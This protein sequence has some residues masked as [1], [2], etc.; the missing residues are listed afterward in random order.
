MQNT[1]PVCGLVDPRKI[2]TRKD[3]PAK[4]SKTRSCA[5]IQ[6][7]VGDGWPA[8]H[9]NIVKKQARE[10]QGQTSQAGC[11]NLR[12]ILSI[13]F[14]FIVG[15]AEHLAVLGGAIAALAPCC[16]VVRVHF[17]E[18]IDPAIVRVVA[19]RTE[20]AVG[21]FLCLCR[22]RLLL[23]DRVLRCIVEHA[24]FKKFRIF[25]A[26]EDEFEYPAFFLNVGVPV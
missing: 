11:G 24:H 6:I 18:L 3:L 21:F 22:A 2:L 17:L 12:P 20:R 16:N 8:A 14:G 1:L 7:S 13:T 10:A 26:A 4:Y 9:A 23:V 25:K 19:N 5:L 15:A